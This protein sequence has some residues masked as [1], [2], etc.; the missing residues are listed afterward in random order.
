ML[1][2]IFLV[3]TEHV[4][5]QFIGCGADPLEEGDQILLQSF[6]PAEKHVVR[7]P[8]HL[9]HLIEAERIVGDSAAPNSTHRVF[10]NVGNVSPAVVNLLRQQ[11]DQSIESFVIDTEIQSVSNATFK[12]EDRKSTR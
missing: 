2:N 11:I 3:R 5:P 1:R 12:S 7:V 6:N 4:I 10:V 9:E 8:E